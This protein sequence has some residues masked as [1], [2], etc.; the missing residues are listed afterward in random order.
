MPDDVLFPPPPT[1]EAIEWPGSAIGAGNCITRTKTRT[2]VFDKAID[3]IE[4]RRDALVGAA[5]AHITR[6]AGRE[7]LYRHDVVIHGVRVRVTTNSP[8]L[9]D[10]WVDNWYGVE[11][12]QAATGRRPPRDPQITVYALGGVADQQEAAYYSR[13]TNTIVFFNTAYYGQLKSWVLGAVGRVLAEEYGI[14]SIHGACVEVDGRGVLYI[15]PTG[16]GKSTSSYGLMAHPRTRFHSDDWVYVRYTYA[17]RDGRRLHPVAVRPAQGS[18]VRGYQVFRWLARQGAER[19]DA[20]VYGLDL[21]H[22]EVA[23][24]V[25]A[26]DLEAPVEA[27]A[28]TSEKIFY[29]RTNLVENFPLAA[30]EMLRSKMENVPE[31]T[32]AFLQRRDPALEDLV[33]AIRREGGAVSE[34]FADTS[35]D[36]L[37]RLLGRL[38][39][40]DNA[41]AMLDIARVLPPERVFTRPLEPARLSTVFL[42][43]RDS[44]DATVAER[45]TLGAFM[46]ALLIGETPEKKREIAYNAYRAVDD[47]EEKLYILGLEHE[48]GGGEVF[49]VFERRQDVPETLR[50]EF[51][52]FRVMHGSCATYGLNTILTADPRV[53]D[54]KEA[55]AL[56]MRLIAV[57]IEHQPQTLRLTLDDYRPFLAASPLR[58]VPSPYPAT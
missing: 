14:H 8:H 30:M 1:P 15:A 26:L 56:T 24:P 46:S 3:R 34:F 33:E 54:R 58:P 23:V 49:R 32:P 10:F 39:A 42:L 43:R 38:I 18:E 47:E 25:R 41:R 5:V 6:R 21:E 22:R 36:Q 16:T 9:Y 35:R 17:L 7:P 29:L 57:L 55:V 45:L 53:R 37:K 19:T 51:E 4:G 2:A 28:Y 13:K 31:I 44:A 12:W 27:Y 11:E 52:L 48:A 20:T 50:E 40:F